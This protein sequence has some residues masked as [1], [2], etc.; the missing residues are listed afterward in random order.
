[1]REAAIFFFFLFFSKALSCLI[2][3]RKRI[4][5]KGREKKRHGYKS[6]AANGTAKNTYYCL[7]LKGRSS[8]CNELVDDRVVPCG[9]VNYGATCMEV[10]A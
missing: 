2:H 7:E 6:T 8:K 3:E 4:V 9:S 1:M 10:A 5:E